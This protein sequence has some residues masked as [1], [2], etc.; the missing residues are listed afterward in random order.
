MDEILSFLP[1]WVVTNLSAKNSFPLKNRLFDYA[2]KLLPIIGIIILI[3]LI[4]L[5]DIDKIKDAFL[6]IE[7]YYIL[8]A[9]SL[10]IPKILILGLS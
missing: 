7:P 4:L 3:V 8:I 2:R 1:V 5:L 9:L 10:T 6:S